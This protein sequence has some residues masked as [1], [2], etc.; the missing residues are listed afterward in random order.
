LCRRKG[1]ENMADE[2]RY[3]EEQLPS[4][5]VSEL[6]SAV[7]Y[8]TDRVNSLSYD[9][10][11][12]QN[13]VNEV[14]NEFQEFLREFRAYVMQDLCDRK[15]QEALQDRVAIA[16]QL[17]EHFSQHQRVR[18]YV[19]GILQA[20]DSKLVRKEIVEVATSELMISIPHYWLVP[21]LVALSAWLNDNKELAEKALKEAMMRD[22][23]KTSLLFALICRRAARNDAAMQW[24][25]RYFAMQDPMCI[26]KKMVVVLDAYANGLFGGDARSMCAEQIGG[27]IVEMEDVAGFRE[28]QVQRWQQAFES[29]TPTS[30]DV[31]YRYLERYATNWSSIKK[32]LCKADLHR[33]L[34]DYIRDVLEQPNGDSAPLR[35]QLDELLDSLVTNYDNAELPLRQQNRIAELIIECKGDE[36]AAMQ[37]FD[38]E[39]SAFE[40]ETDLMQLL[41]NAAMN[42]EAVNAS[43]ATRKLSMAVSKDWM[44]EAYQNVIIN[45]QATAVRNIEID[46]EGFKG[47]TVE[48]DNE[49][50][51]CQKLK[52]HFEKVRDDAIRGE[53]QSPMDYFFLGGGALLM[54]LG[55]CGVLPWFIGLLAA[56]GG[57]IKFWLGRKQVEKNIEKLKCRYAD[58][59]GDGKEIVRAL[60]AETVDFRRDLAEREKKYDK[61]MEYMQR[62][63]PHQFIKSSGERTI[64][65]AV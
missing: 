16:Q 46:I 34:L 64:R 11:S 43:E 47:E 27:W 10:V 22:D 38:A 45:N 53:K 33:V 26:E 17:D 59:I 21:A 55:F 42:P 19:T 40:E 15:Y 6:F 3:V 12:V 65:A 60:C 36:A 39:K 51:L 29:K 1:S 25:Q 62:I 63:V 31:S 61:T 32:T 57:G 48:G 37:K 56:A 7:N 44:I 52:E 35:K 5:R 50:E 49:E 41:T 23:E 4:A 18:R 13:R 8:M 28:Q 20:S 2:I 30:V 14:T 24:L 54:I 58:M 9:A